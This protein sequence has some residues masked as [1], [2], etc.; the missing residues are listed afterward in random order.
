MKGAGIKSTSEQDQ[1]GSNLIELDWIGLDWIG[2]D[3]IGLDWIGLDWIGLDWI[4]LDWIGLDWIGLDWI[5]LDWIGLDWIGLDWIGLDWIRKIIDPWHTPLS[6]SKQ[7][8][9]SSSKLHVACTTTTHIRHRQPST[10][11]DTRAD[12]CENAQGTD[13]SSSHWRTL[14][15]GAL[16]LGPTVEPVPAGRSGLD[17]SRLATGEIARA[18]RKGAFL[19][20]NRA[21]DVRV[22]TGGS[23]ALP[24]SRVLTPESHVCMSYGELGTGRESGRMLAPVDLPRR[25]VLILREG[26]KGTESHNIPEAITE[27]GGYCA[28][29]NIKLG[30]QE[31]GGCRCQTSKN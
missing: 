12:V 13:T 18:E 19:A 10:V 27:S 11:Q 7:L 29:T 21:E 23:Y 15:G 1:I 28:R 2:L 30:Y 20:G 14:S 26:G 16:A 25:K 8:G 4:G 24:R 3:W 5:G 31:S 9:S 22:G 6:S 17:R